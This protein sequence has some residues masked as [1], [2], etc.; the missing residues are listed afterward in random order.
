MTLFSTFCGF[1]IKFQN[2]PDFWV[3]MYYVNPMT[4]AFEGLVTTQFNRDHTMITVT[5]TTDVMTAQSY[6]QDFYSDWR[7]SSR[8]YD[9]MALV[10]FIIVFRYVIS[11]SCVD[12]A[13]FVSP[14]LFLR[15]ISYRTA[16]SF[17]VSTE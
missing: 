14:L 6:V 12:L 13:F 15:F 4:Y 5:G 7:Y 16:V 11:L 9:L 1:T 2:F 17:F 3:F 10:L 8:G